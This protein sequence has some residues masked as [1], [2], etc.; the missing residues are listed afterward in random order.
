MALGYFGI[1]AFQHQSEAGDTTQITSLSKAAVS[2]FQTITPALLQAQ[3]VFKSSAEGATTSTQGL[4]TRYASA[5]ASTATRERLLVAK[6]LHYLGFSL[7]LL[8]KH[9]KADLIFPFHYF[10]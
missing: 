9:R 8:V 6:Q 2:D 7:G 5:W 3:A 4:K 10:W 1:T